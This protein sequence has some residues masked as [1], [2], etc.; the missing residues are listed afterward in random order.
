MCDRLPLKCGQRKLK[1]TSGKKPRIPRLKCDF[2]QISGT[3]V[4]VSSFVSREELWAE[5]SYAQLG[6]PEDEIFT[7]ERR[8]IELPAYAPIH[9]SAVC[10]V[11]GESVMETK[12]RLRD[13]DS[14]C[15]A[16]A[17]AQRFVLDGSGML[18]Q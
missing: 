8:D 12:A 13:G 4:G 18:V 1:R 7:V 6:V 16:C 10:A 17:G 3:I 5:A 9:E 11:C 15:I 14:V 2:L